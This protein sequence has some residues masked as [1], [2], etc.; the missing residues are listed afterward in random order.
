MKFRQILANVVNFASEKWPINIHQ[1]MIKLFS[2]CDG[3]AVSFHDHQTRW[4]S[5]SETVEEVID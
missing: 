1:Q 3:G 5:K 4:E 2:M